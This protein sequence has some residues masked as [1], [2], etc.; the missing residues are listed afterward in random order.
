MKNEF[1]LTLVVSGTDA[2]VEGGQKAV[3]AAMRHPA[4]KP[5]REGLTVPG[6]VGLFYDLPLVVKP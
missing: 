4:F 2:H 3:F 1:K 5:L 6:Q